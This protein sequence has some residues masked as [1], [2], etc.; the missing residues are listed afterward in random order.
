MSVPDSL[1][2]FPDLDD[3]DCDQ[4]PD[5][6]TTGAD[7]E[8]STLLWAYAQGYFPMP[9]PA[10]QQGLWWF[11]PRKRGVLPLEQLRITRSLRQSAKRYE[12]RV[13]T[14][15]DEVI[16][17]CAHPS[18][19][20]AWIDDD[21]IAAY[22]SLH[23]LGWAH[24][25]ET[26]DGDELV[27]GLYGVAIGGLFA[28][29]SMFYRARDAS[30]VALAGLVELLGDEHTEH[31]LLDVQWSTPHLAGLGVIELPRRV[32]LARLREALQLPLPV[33]WR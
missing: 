3:P 5:A 28:G 14:A 29:E 24:S 4:V 31:R 11:S 27:G 9:S 13:D 30:K 12:V 32:Y 15:F 25:I 19:E 1:W 26:F 6:V 7:L 17:A 8:P 16:A 22:R 20:G 18:R 21:I 2:S 33:P 23:D 10:G